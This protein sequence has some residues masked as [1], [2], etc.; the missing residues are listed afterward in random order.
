MADDQQSFTAAYMNAYVWAQ[1]L[2]GVEVRDSPQL[3]CDESNAVV[4]MC[5]EHL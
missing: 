3:A 2:A 1:L 5:M 4:L